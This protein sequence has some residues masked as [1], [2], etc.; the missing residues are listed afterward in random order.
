MRRCRRLP[1]LTLCSQPLCPYA[2]SG[3]MPLRAGR[4]GPGGG[5]RPPLT[6]PAWAPG[7]SG[8]HAGVGLGGAAL[9]CSWSPSCCA[10]AAAL[11]CVMPAAQRLKVGERVVVAVLHVVHLIARLPAQD[12]GRVARLAA[13]A[14]TPEDTD[15]ARAPVTRKASRSGAGAVGG[16]GHRGGHLLGTGHGRAWGVGL[17]RGEGVERQSPGPAHEERDR[18]GPRSGC[19]TTRSPD[20]RAVARSRARRARSRACAERSNVSSAPVAAALSWSRLS[21][22]ARSPVGSATPG[23]RIPRDSPRGAPACAGWYCASAIVLNAEARR[24]A[25]SAWRRTCAGSAGRPVGEARSGSST[26]W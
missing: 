6:L 18:G 16:P 5:P 14:V 8:D 21:S 12:A 7:G 17:A 10:F 9:R 24:S 23:E 1:G 2:L 22:A 15:A 26:P 25:S 20:Q 3:A 13:V 4:R 11:A 19:Q